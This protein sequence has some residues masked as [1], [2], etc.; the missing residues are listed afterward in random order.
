MLHESVQQFEMHALSWEDQSVKSRTQ[1]IDAVHIIG[2][3]VVLCAKRFV[4]V[5]LQMIWSKS[6]NCLQTVYTLS[7]IIP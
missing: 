6:Q 7:D 1:V 4:M 3:Y 2:Y 5:H